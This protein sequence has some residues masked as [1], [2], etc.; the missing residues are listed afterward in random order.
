M[1]HRYHAIVL[2]ANLMDRDARLNAESR[3]RADR[4]AQLLQAGLAPF[5]LCCGWA[6][7]ADSPVAIGVALR[8]YLL[9]AGVAPSQLQV[10]ERSR[11][12]VGDAVYSRL[13][14]GPAAPLVV[15]SDYHVDRTREVFGFVYGLPV[16]VEGAPVAA[17]DRAAAEAE[18]LAAFRRTFAGVQAGDI[19]RIEARMLAKHP[20]YNGEMAPKFEAGQGRGTGGDPR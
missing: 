14:L 2:L 6:Y 11:D 7:R 15:T 13:R 9:H 10:E 17:A 8:D 4:A 1:G 18:S 12:T 19:A 5:V 20:L 3:A 16:E